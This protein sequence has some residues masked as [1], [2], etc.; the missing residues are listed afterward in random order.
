MKTQQLVLCLMA[1][2]PSMSFAQ[3]V[4][5]NPVAGSTESGIGV[6]SGW[7]CTAGSIVVAIDGASI[8]NAGIGT[9]RGDTASIC[10]RPD[11]GFSLLFNYN[12]LTPGS[13]TLGPILFT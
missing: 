5:E 2:I 7:N 10:G 8:G 11:T 12:S 1:A 13:H 6:V 3:G 9:S 4:L